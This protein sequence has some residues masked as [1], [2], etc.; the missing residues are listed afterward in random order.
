MARPSA[1]T[2]LLLD[3]LLEDGKK[4]TKRQGAKISVYGLNPNGLG[5]R[6][7]PRLKNIAS[8][9]LYRP[10]AGNLSDYENLQPI[11]SK[12]IDWDLIRNQ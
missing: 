8:Q 3:E 12:T 2:P 10:E 4:L 9:K 5:F 6:L 11:L 1:T 7:L